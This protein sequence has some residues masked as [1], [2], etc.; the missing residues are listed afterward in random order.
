MRGRWALGA[1][2]VALP[3]RPRRDT[4]ICDESN[5]QIVGT[6]SQDG[7]LVAPCQGDHELA[8]FLRAAGCALVADAAAE[9]DRQ[10]LRSIVSSTRE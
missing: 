10:A 2:V 3:S 4:H 7:L 6:E 5:D 9:P 1:L 8:G